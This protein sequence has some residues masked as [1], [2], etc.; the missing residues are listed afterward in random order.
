MDEKDTIWKEKSYH[1]RKM[2]FSEVFT[3]QQTNSMFG[4]PAS[5][6]IDKNLRLY[7]NTIQ[8]DIDNC[9]IVD[10]SLRKIDCAIYRESFYERAVL[11]DSVPEDIS[12]SNINYLSGLPQIVPYLTFDEY[13]QYFPDTDKLSFPYVFTLEQKEYYDTIKDLQ[14]KLRESAQSE[15]IERSI[16]EMG[17][18][19]YIPIN[20]ESIKCARERQGR[21]LNHTAVRMYDIAELSNFGTE[22]SDEIL[23]ETEFAQ[24]L[25]EPIYIVLSYTNTTFGKVIKAYQH[26]TYTHAGLA[27]EPTLGKIW[28]FNLQPK[29][30]I[31]GLSIES[32]DEYNDEN[33]NVKLKILVVFISSEAKKKLK[34]VL[35]WFEDHIEN[36]SYSIQNIFNI[37]LN[38]SQN[39]LYNTSMVCSQFVDSVLKL[40]N[41]DITNRSSNLVSPKTFEKIEQKEGSNF[42]VYSVFKGWK[43]EYSWKDIK[44]KVLALLRMTTNNIDKQQVTTEQAISLLFDRKIENLNLYITDKK[45]NEAVT[46]L[47]E[48]MI[49]IAVIQEIKSPIGFTKKGDLYINRKEDLQLEYNEAHKLLYMY[50]QTNTE[51]IKHELA[52]LFYLNSIIEKKLKKSKSDTTEEYKEL[53]DLRAR[54]LNDFTTYFKFLKTTEPQFD[55]MGYMKN[56]EYYNKTI[57]V[58][59]STLKYSGKLIKGFLKNIV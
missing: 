39:I 53:I 16:L 48:S 24:K 11:E 57:V 2:S 43:T 5:Q 51:G 12:E 59:N 10:L 20:G 44:R 46:N 6:I 21:F 28:S 7:Q 37:V 33:G 40:C 45:V 29:L 23:S 3:E 8:E 52:R 36:T 15:E 22:L 34:K 41:I 9:N 55:F 42:R 19:P 35:K 14:H 27:L 4:D 18:N 17:W 1:D 31:N 25:L 26:S 49:P 54:I 13:K 50:D 58:D 30:K 32:L 47:R 56:S 38:R